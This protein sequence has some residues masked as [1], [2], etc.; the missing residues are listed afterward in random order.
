ME[1]IMEKLKKLKLQPE[2]FVIILKSIKKNIKKFL[3]EEFIY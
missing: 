3:I 1:K 2:K